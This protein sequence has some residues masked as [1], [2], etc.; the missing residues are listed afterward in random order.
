M[1]ETR[2]ERCVNSDIKGAD[3][4][5]LQTEKERII[6]HI[7]LLY[8]VIERREEQGKP[9]TIDDVVNDFRKALSGDE[10]M[11]DVRAKSRIDFPLRRDIISIGR[12]FKG[13]FQYVFTTP[14]KENGE[15][16]SD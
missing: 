7:R 4:S 3:E 12:E 11:A 6:S 9:F 16:L 14:A 15:N 13:T 2:I 1:R 10:S 5:I 8:C